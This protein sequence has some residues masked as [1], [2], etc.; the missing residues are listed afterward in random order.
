[1]RLRTSS[2]STRFAHRTRATSRSGTPRPGAST[3]RPMPWSSRL[4]SPLSI[5]VEDRLDR[6][7]AHGAERHVVAREHDAVGLRAEVAARLVVRTF[8]R[9]DLSGVLPFVQERRVALLLLAEQRVH[10]GLRPVLRADLAAALL[11]LLRVALEL[12]L[13][14]WRRQAHARRQEILPLQRRRIEHGRR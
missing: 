4:S 14:P 12:V 11:N 5:E 13:R 9:A 1:M 8:E 6:A 10:L 3:P 2:L 7:T